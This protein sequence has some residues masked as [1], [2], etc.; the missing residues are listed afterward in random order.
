MGVG[1]SGRLTRTRTRWR[2]TPRNSATSAKP[3]TSGS[4]RS[5]T[6]R[7][8]P[9]IGGCITYNSPAMIGQEMVRGESWEGS[10]TAVLQELQKLQA[11][12]MLNRY[13]GRDLSL[14]LGE[15]DA[16]LEPSS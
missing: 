9:P 4:D 6:I 12:L 15:D 11:R 14:C 16:V 7:Q 13:V 2:D 8:A 1:K 3:H 5:P 10:R